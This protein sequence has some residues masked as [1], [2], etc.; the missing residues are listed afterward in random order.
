[1]R[2]L[3]G[4]AFS[5]GV[6]LSLV[7]QVSAEVVVVDISGTDGERTWNDQIRVD[8][9]PDGTFFWTGSSTTE[10]WDADLLLTGDIDPVVT[11]NFSGQ[12]LLGVP[13]ILTVNAFLPVA[14]PL[15][16]PTATSGTVAYTVTDGSLPQNGA[17]VATVAGSSLYE[18]LIDGSSFMTL[19]DDP[20]SLVA[21]PGGSA[22]DSTD[23]GLP[24]QT[25]IGPAVTT[26]MEITYEFSLTPN[27]LVSITGNFVALPIP[28]PSSVVLCGLGM[29]AAA[30]V[31]RRSAR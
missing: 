5:L 13:V 26:S 18:A 30:M 27:D 9:D 4:V 15:G 23:F 31:V 14:P 28:E 16:A 17:T 21:A 3:L 2:R 19:F 11:A 25:T 8:V 20:Y 22:T 7:G 12:N 10:A 6:A 1:M 24:G 29:L